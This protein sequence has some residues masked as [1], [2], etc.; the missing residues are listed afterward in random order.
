MFKTGAKR[1]LRTQWWNT[2]AADL[3]LRIRG[4]EFD[5]VLALCDIVTDAPGAMFAEDI[6]RFY[7]EAK[8]GQVYP[9]YS[10]ILLSC[11]S[12]GCIALREYL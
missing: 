7:A 6:A 8:V 11:T 4:E 10:H 1:Q 12:L 3:L 9:L 2:K 5:R